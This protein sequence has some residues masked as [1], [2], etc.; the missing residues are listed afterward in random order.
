MAQFETIL[1]QGLL[2]AFGTVFFAGIAT[3]LTGCVYPMIPITVALFGAKETK[4]R[5]TAFLLATSYVM[6]IGLMYASLGVIAALTGRAA[7]GYSA[8]VTHNLVGPEGAQVLVDQTVEAI[9]ALWSD[10][11]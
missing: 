4:S 5:L 7:G 1:A 10:S 9:G 11:K 6:G 8:E 3:S 2:W